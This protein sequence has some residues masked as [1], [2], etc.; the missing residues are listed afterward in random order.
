[1]KHALH[2]YE[3]IQ[4]PTAA[5][6]FFQ[7]ATRKK[8]YLDLAFSHVNIAPMAKSITSVAHEQLTYTNSDFWES[9]RECFYFLNTKRFHVHADPGTFFIRI[10]SSEPSL[11]DVFGFASAI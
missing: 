9:V 3:R 5:S 1:M 7:E 2:P 8:K 4:R 10:V 6:E 11:T